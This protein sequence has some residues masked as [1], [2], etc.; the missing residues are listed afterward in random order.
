MTYLKCSLCGF[1]NKGDFRSC[2][3]CG[4]GVYVLKQDAWISALWHI[5]MFFFGFAA[6]IAAIVLWIAL[7]YTQGYFF[8]ILFIGF[9]LAGLGVLFGRRFPES[10]TRVTVTTA[11]PYFLIQG[12]TVLSGVLYVTNPEYDGV[13]WYSEFFLLPAI[14]YASPIAVCALGAWT[15]SR[16]SFELLGILGL[17]LLLTFIGIASIK[18][19]E[20][21]T[22]TSIFTYDLVDDENAHL[23]V[24]VKCE[25]TP[26]KNYWG[27][28]DLTRS[29][30]SD[31]KVTVVS[32]RPELPL[33]TNAVWTYDGREEN[34]TMWPIN[35]PDD[36]GVM[37]CF[38]PGC[39]DNIRRW[40]MWFSY[41]KIA[42]A[43][44][45]SFTWGDL[46]VDFGEKQLE[47]MRAFQESVRKLMAE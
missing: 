9:G 32:K 6:I 20:P 43:K 11:M 40:S 39:Y 26:K 14:L 21:V 37:D 10:V 38:E 4:G 24:D 15:G 16:R 7:S 8:V 17:S 27:F 2:P 12:Y 29:A 5:A 47:S 36:T 35:R 1:V 44:Q 23:S 3:R 22:R 30:C 31:T 41:A 25:Y 33:P 13:F 46:R 42:Q 19:D 34:V 18:P 28:M 45:V